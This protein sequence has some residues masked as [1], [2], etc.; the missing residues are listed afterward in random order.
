MFSI[1]KV[2][3]GNVHS[4]LI[5]KSVSLLLKAKAYDVS[6][7]PE[8]RWDVQLTTYTLLFGGSHFHLTR[9]SGATLGTNFSKGKRFTY[10]LLAV[11]FVRIHSANLH[12]SKLFPHT[13]NSPT[14]KIVSISWQYDR[15]IPPLNF[16]S[17]MLPSLF[18]SSPRF[19]R[20]Q[21]QLYVFST[22]IM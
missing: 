18:A 14:A 17:V 4:L 15:W 1:C 20:S 12:V 7:K 16:C 3:V 5:S 13:L 8:D 10:W 19:S 11:L 9:P 22:T 21:H 2:R 6:H